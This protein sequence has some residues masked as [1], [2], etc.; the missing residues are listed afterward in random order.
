MRNKGFTLIELVIAMLLGTFVILG[1]SVMF[2]FVSVNWLSQI[3][4]YFGQ[5]DLTLLDNLINTQFEGLL[6]DHA[7]RISG[8]EKRLD[9]FTRKSGTF[10]PSYV[11]VLY[12]LSDDKLKICF[13]PISVSTM[14]PPERTEY[15][16]DDCTFLEKVSDVTFSYLLRERDVAKWYNTV[17]GA[18]PMALSLEVVFKSNDENIT[19]VI[20]AVR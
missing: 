16:E 19:K 5:E 6:T 3:R 11:H 15:T 2:R 18:T 4:G 14:I 20:Y 8:D 1:V 9:F 7:H 10:I 12:E 17:K 13:K